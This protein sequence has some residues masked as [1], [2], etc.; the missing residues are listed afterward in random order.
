METPWK[1]AEHLRQ[2][3]HAEALRELQKRQ[4]EMEAALQAC[5]EMRRRYKDL[6][7][8]KT[9]MTTSSESTANTVSPAS[10]P[11]K[12]L[13]SIDSISSIQ[14][15]GQSSSVETTACL[16]GQA[17]KIDSARR[18]ADDRAT[19]PLR[20]AQTQSGQHHP[21]PPRS[22]GGGSGVSS[23]GAIHRTVH[24]V[25]LELQREADQIM[26][27]HHYGASHV[28]QLSQVKTQTMLDQHQ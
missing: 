15:Q 13:P 25:E 18:Y 21:V 17:R 28:T 24:S 1:Q 9:G 27:R 14:S 5:N 20:T 7:L 2:Q 10:I 16:D 23:S 11:L 22:T 19:P 12:A 6:A 26:D 3:E 4:R 8:P